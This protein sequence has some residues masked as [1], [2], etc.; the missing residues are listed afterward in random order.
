M[1]IRPSLFRSD[2]KNKKE[3]RMT[4]TQKPR[5]R[6]AI[7]TRKST[8]EGLDME[9]NTLDAQRDAAEAYILSQRHEGWTLVADHYDDGG[10]SGGNM[11]RPALKRLVE[12]IKKGLIN[13]VV[14]Y[15]I[16]RLTRSLMDFSQLVSAFDQH[17][18]SFVSVTQQFNTTTSMGRLTLNILL[19]F[20]QFE[21]EV[22]GERI[23]DKVAA[24]K[25]K[26]MWMGGHPPLGYDVKD[27]H[28][29]VNK[30]EAEIIKHI[31]SRFITL[32][33]M[34]TLT[35]ELRERG[36]RTKTFVTQKSAQRHGTLVS[37]G[38]IYRVLN[39]A[40]YVGDMPHKDKVYPGQHEAII[41][42][43]IWNEVHTILKIS[44]RVR[45]NA[46]RRKQP[47]ILRGLAAC[48]GCQSVM[49][50]CGTRKK[51]KVYS[52]YAGS[53]YLTL[54]CA[55]FLAAAPKDADKDRLGSQLDLLKSAMS[56]QA[57]TLGGIDGDIA[58]K[59]AERA[60]MQ[61]EIAKLQDT[62]PLIEKRAQMRHDLIA[63]G[64]S[65]VMEESKEQQNLIE[66]RQTLVEDKHKLDEDKGAL[67]QLS[68]QRAAAVAKFR[69]ETLS[70]LAEASRKADD[71]RQQWIKASDLASHRVL[72]APVDGTVQQLAVHTVGGVVTPAQQLMAIVPADAKLEVEAMVQN[73]DIGFVHEG[74]KAELKLETFPFTRYG[75]RHGTVE[76][77]S[78]DAVTPQERQPEK[79]NA[80]GGADTVAPP[81]AKDSLYTARISLDQ[82][83]MMIDG[84]KVELSPGMTVTAEIKT[85]KQ[86]IL[87]YLLDPLLRYRDGSFHER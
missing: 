11:E 24:S 28:L 14:V 77:L 17:N 62:L 70:Q 84:K 40:V 18:V 72:T 6:C 37:P 73:K 16:D 74:Q 45:G 47:A 63:K 23:R 33:S 75:L 19:S 55:D 21:R 80:A 79:G 81:S 43:D 54:K 68:Q 76:G 64:Y 5:I 8:E 83:F 27:R 71:A 3:N 31:F 65:S 4:A 53:K 2:A 9:Y 46:S 10:F 7:Y 42:R 66:T 38:Y 48:G 82:N 49:S 30:E 1:D 60:Q 25:R 69:A 32:K 39:N 41:S 56:Q 52:Y 34:S 20:A 36:V 13:V 67:R 12:D 35:R 57:A 78:R 44:P 51:G 15:K 61:A 22:T 86:R 87:D 29:H 50:P 59:K 85:G 26:G 58:Q